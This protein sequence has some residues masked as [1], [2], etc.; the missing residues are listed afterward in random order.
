M[1]LPF[2]LLRDSYLLALPLSVLIFNDFLDRKKTIGLCVFVIVACI[3][4]RCIRLNYNAS[5]LDK[6]AVS[7]NMCLAA[8]ILK[9]FTIKKDGG[10]LNK[11]VFLLLNKISFSIYFLHIL[12]EEKL[13]KAVLRKILPT[14]AEY[15]SPLVGR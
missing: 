11:P 2:F 12:V 1:F 14:V 5:F 8:S 3:G 13:T 10:F 15:T 9:L 4:V 7:N 6:F